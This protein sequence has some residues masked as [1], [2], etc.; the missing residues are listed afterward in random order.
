MRHARRLVPTEVTH[1]RMIA[2]YLRMQ[3]SQLLAALDGEA[4]LRALDEAQRVDEALEHDASF[5]SQRA[6]A[7]EASG[8]LEAAERDRDRGRDAGV[9]R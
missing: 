1:R 3:A 8:D 6:A 7:H 4:A 2:Y 5:W 9:E